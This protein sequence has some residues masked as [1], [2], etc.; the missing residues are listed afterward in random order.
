[1]LMRLAGGAGWCMRVTGGQMSLAESVYLGRGELVERSR[2]IVIEGTTGAT[3]ATVKWAIQ[4]V[5][6]GL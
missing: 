6:R 4:S 5:G 1:M 3:G 2:Q